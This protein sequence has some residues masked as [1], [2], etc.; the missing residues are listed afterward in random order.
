MKKLRAIEE[1]KNLIKEKKEDKVEDKEVLL[2]EISC[3]I[4]NQ[5]KMKVLEYPLS[6]LCNLYNLTFLI[7]A[8]NLIFNPKVLGDVPQY[9]YE[10]HG[11]VTTYDTYSNSFSVDMNQFL[12]KDEEK[13]ITM[14]KKKG[15]DIIKDF[16]KAKIKEKECEQEKERICQ[17]IIQHMKEVLGESDCCYLKSLDTLKYEYIEVEYRGHITSEEIEDLIDYMQK[18]HE[19]KMKFLESRK[20]FE[21]PLK[22]F[23]DEE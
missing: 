5:I 21:V 1:I 22:Q 10:N 17:V 7:K 14:D 6:H 3:C 18:N 19:I 15:I 11:I 12:V 20:L 2:S 4:V 16:I 9:L 23:F 8:N 13:E